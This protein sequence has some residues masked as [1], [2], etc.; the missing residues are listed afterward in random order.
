MAVYA[1]GNVG[2]DF[3]KQLDNT[4]YARVVLW[5]DRQYEKKPKEL[6][7]MPP[8]QL[9]LHK[10]DYEYVIVAIDEEKIALKVM[11]YLKELNIPEDKLIWQN[12]RRS[13]YE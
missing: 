10:N 11:E 12:Y 4:L 13:D 2:Q 1:A 8:E 9:A 7:I 5:V 6:G 3:V